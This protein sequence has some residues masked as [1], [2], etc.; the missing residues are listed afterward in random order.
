MGVLGTWVKLLRDFLIFFV[1]RPGSA[2]TRRGS[3][4]VT[5]DPLAVIRGNDWS[6]KKG[7]GIGR[8]R[9]GGKREGH[10]GVGRDGKGWW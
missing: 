10:K 6:G 3:Y 5:P 4:S 9:K 2:Q 8:E 7:L 1:W